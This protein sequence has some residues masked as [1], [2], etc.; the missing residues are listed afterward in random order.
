MLFSFNGHNGVGKVLEVG[1]F[2]R[3]FG[4]VVMTLDE[5]V[6]ILTKWLKKRSI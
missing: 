5:F 1:Y 4:G 6:I 3:K 2:A